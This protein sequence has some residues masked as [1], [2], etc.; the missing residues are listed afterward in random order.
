MNSCN[1]F[2]QGY[3]RD[4]VYHTNSQAEIEAVSEDI[5]GDMLHDS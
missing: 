1:Y 3:L 4:G 2:L 5:K